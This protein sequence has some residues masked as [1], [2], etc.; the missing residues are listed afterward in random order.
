MSIHH[1]DAERFFI[2][3]IIREKLHHL[4]YIKMNNFIEQAAAAAHMSFCQTHF[5]F[6][7]STSSR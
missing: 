3:D 1:F 7:I 4:A 5:I 2:C 6:R